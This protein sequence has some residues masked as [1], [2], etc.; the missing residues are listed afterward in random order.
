M[1]LAIKAWQLGSHDGSRRG[2]SM[3]GLLLE[4]GEPST[5]LRAWLITIWLRVHHVRDDVASPLPWDL[6]FLAFGLALL[7]VGLGLVSSGRR[8]T[9]AGELSRGGIDTMEHSAGGGVR[10]GAGRP[11]RR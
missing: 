3:V 11:G 6:G 1:W 9:S 4:V 7:A 5:W 8:P 10:P 2:E